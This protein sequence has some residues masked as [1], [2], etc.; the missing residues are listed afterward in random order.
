MTLL[1]SCRVAG[2]QHHLGPRF[3]PQ[4]KAGEL[5]TLRREPAN[6][7]DPRAI[8]VEWR[9]AMLGYVPREANFAAAQL[10]DR[11]TALTARIAELRSGGDPRHRLVIEVSA[12]APAE[13]PAP[14]VATTLCAVLLQGHGGEPPAL[15]LA[16][17]APASGA[18]HQKALEVL[19]DAVAAIARRLAAPNVAITS[20]TG[21]EVR[22]WE[23]LAIAVD[24]RGRE[25]K[26][27]HLNERPSMAPRVTLDLRRPVSAEHWLEAMQ[28]VI[29]RI[30]REHGLAAALGPMP[31]ARWIHACLRLTFQDFLDFE[32]LRRQ[33]VSHLAA[34]PLACSLANR[35]F[36]PSPE[37]RE[38]NWVCARMEALALIAVDAP[39]MVP[40]LHLLH[41]DRGCD[42]LA[43]AEGLTGRLKTLVPGL[44]ADKREPRVFRVLDRPREGG[45]AAAPQRGQLPLLA[46]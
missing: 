20:R 2:F 24:S 37:A 7:H 35:I 26:V 11:G 13:H 40:Y 16:D 28:P 15:V 46:A 3:M 18:V 14:P 41:A 45:D 29:S 30:V 42:A 27:T 6:R 8:R 39:R 36:A 34:D 32:S 5:L 23:T 10:I 38:F 22:L 12:E 1:M 25:L 4:L 43:S 17:D 44:G 19:D 9:G 33:L 31:L 21:R